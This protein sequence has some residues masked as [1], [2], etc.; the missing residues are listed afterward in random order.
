LILLQYAKKYNLMREELLNIII[1]PKCRNIPLSLE[2]DEVSQLEIISGKI[3]C[4]Y[5]G[6]EFRISEGIIDFLKE[7]NED[8]FRERRAMDDDEYIT[9]ELGNKHKITTET[10][11]K[12]KNILITLP[13]GDGS[14]FFKKGGSFQTIAEASGRFYSTL[15]SLHLTGKEK[16][17]EIGACFS[18][19]SFKFAK[20]GCSV[21][22]LDI[23]NYLKAS[24]LFIKDAYFD[25]IFS[26]MHNIPFMDNAFDIVFG[27][28]VV[29]HSKNPEAVFNEIHRILKNGGKLILINEPSRGIFERIHPVFEK[30][31]KKGFGDTSYTIP[32][33]QRSAQGSQFKK[34]KIEFLSLADDYITK[35]KNRGTQYNFKLKLAYFFM[36]HRKIEKLMLS[37]LVLP[38]LLFRPRSWRLI[39]YK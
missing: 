36:N 6:I 28:A 14:Y 29:H 21:V 32:Q 30:M 31:Q 26:D 3:M 13:E 35:H 18:Y 10:I 22:A 20:K 34:I 12:F 9:D 17:L 19:A 24:S 23:S 38:R 15:D 5:C 8:V 7:A 1:C 11:Q 2:K 37:I 39:G 4:N 25:R 16:I 33:W 27:A